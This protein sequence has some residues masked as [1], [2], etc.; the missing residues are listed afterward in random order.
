MLHSIEL[1]FGSWK[2]QRQV[3]A[4]ESRMAQNYLHAGVRATMDRACM[5]KEI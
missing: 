5:E 1:H 2:D 4:Q 3:T